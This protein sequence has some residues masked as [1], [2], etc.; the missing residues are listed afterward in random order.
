MHPAQYFM[1]GLQRWALPVCQAAL[2]MKMLLLPIGCTADKE[3]LT[4][5]M[6][7]C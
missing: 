5:T 7:Q 1:S 3:T 4:A 2:L 6:A